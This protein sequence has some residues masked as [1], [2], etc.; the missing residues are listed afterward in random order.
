MRKVDVDRFRAR[1]A[2]VDWAAY[3]QAR[4]GGGRPAAVIA[5]ERKTAVRNVQLRWA[6]D[7]ALGYPISPFTVWARRSAT[8]A[9][10]V[11]FAQTPIGIALDQPCVDVRIALNGNATGIAWAYPGMPLATGVVDWKPIAAGTSQVRLTGPRI[12]V[13]VL[14]AGVTVTSVTGIAEDVADDPAWSEVEIVGL[15]GDGRPSSFT[16][17]LAPQGLVTALTD[18]VSAALDRF[19]RGA[20]FYGWPA[21]V[22]PGVSVPPWQLADP[23]ALVGF[24]QHEMLGDFIDMLDSTTPS[25]QQTKDYVRTLS[26]S[27]GRSADATFNPLRLLLYGGLSDPLSALLLGLGTA[28]PL[29]DSLSPVS[30]VDRTADAPDF[31]VTATF[32]DE[33]GNKVERAALA[34][35]PQSSLPPPV[36]AAMS[37]QSPGVQ[38][39]LVIDDPYRASVRVSWDTPADLLPFDVASHA[40]AR[41]LVNPPGP[42]ELLMQPRSTADPALQPLGASSNEQDPTRRALADGGCPISSTTVPTDVRYAVA[43]QNLFGQWS[44]WAEVA[45][46]L[47]EPPVSTVPVTAAHLQV[48]HYDASSCTVTLTMDVSWNWTSRSPETLEVVART[49]PQTWAQDQP[50]AGPPAS[51]DTV[52]TSGAGR[53]CTLTASPDGTIAATAGAGLS[54]TVSHLAVDGQ[55]SSPTPLQDREVRRYRVT[56]EGLRLDLTTTTQWGVALWGTGREARAGRRISP[57]GN[58]TVLSCADPRPPVITTQHEDVTLASLRDADGLHHGRLSWTAMPGSV[59]YQ[60]YTCAE[61][62]L[63]SFRG[64]SPPLPSD[65][66]SDRLLRLRQLLATDCSR[67]AFTRI[68]TDPVIG[69]ATPVTLPR[70]TKEIHLYLVIG[71]SGGNVESAWPDP[72]D[73]LCSR[74]FQ[75]LAA[76]VTI[77][78]AAPALEVTRVAAGDPATYSAQLRIACRPGA[79]VGRIDIHRVRVPEAAREVPTMGPPLLSLTGPANGFT[80]TPS[81]STAPGDDQPLG[82]I[83]G[84]DPVAGSWKP[85][86][87]RVVAHGVD[88][89]TRGQYGVRSAPSVTRAVVVPPPGPP[90]LVSPTAVLPVAGSADVRIESATTAP[91]ADTTS[92]PHRIMAQALLQDAQGVSTTVELTPGSSTLAELPTAAPASGASGLWREARSAGSTPLRL[93]VRRPDAALAVRVQLRLTDPLGRMTEKVIDVPAIDDGVVPDLINPTVTVIT[94]GWLLSFVTH[95]PDNAAGAPCTLTVGTWSL[96]LLRHATTTV[97][98]AT[99]ATPPRDPAALLADPSVATPAY[100]TARTGGSRTISIGFRAAVRAQITLTAGTQSTTINRAI[101]GRQQ[102]GPL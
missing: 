84:T 13:I 59:A 43:S 61:S 65:T 79:R 87:Y 90:D 29:A 73:P 75:A 53:L 62:N 50:P 54:C 63:L 19:R 15:P 67:R 92:G 74:R 14:P 68:G 57:F 22:A 24:F 78:P 40:F 34:L 76:P 95:L 88:D 91:E 16:D 41:R 33:L 35:G 55:T 72:S 10:S 69:T 70:G 28:Y 26:T 5:G 97:D 60:I 66:L 99:L 23:T 44:A 1:A 64:Q 56:V 38:P 37:A 85:V 18:P 46:S 4:P 96:R 11:G 102:I 82:V 101:G 8:E 52:V 42:P 80:V 51:T 45:Q 58:P 12:C 30:R 48:D 93:L 25:T 32:L 20:P 7:G 83:E 27:N 17:L 89:P 100:A 81:P 36:P 94:G 2:I 3:A 6:F 31:M 86:F 49:Y 98:V 39:P 71:V 77:A 47:Q 9:G 21:E